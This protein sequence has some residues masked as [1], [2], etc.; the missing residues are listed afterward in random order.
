MA[1]LDIK[2]IQAAHGSQFG[3]P[4]NEFAGAARGSS[5]PW[6]ARAYHG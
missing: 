4:G 3:Q 6:N 1:E 2:D 5:Q